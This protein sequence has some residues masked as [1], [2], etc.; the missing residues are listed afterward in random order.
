M[1]RAIQDAYQADIE[2][3]KSGCVSD[4]DKVTAREGSDDYAGLQSALRSQVGSRNTFRLRWA[5]RGQGS[6]FEK[7]RTPSWI[8]SE[9]PIRID[10]SE[11][12]T[13]YSTVSR[14]YCSMEAPGQ[15]TL[16][17]IIVHELTGHGIGTVRSRFGFP[18]GEDAA[19]SWQNRIP[20]PGSPAC[21]YRD[22]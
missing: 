15:W 17:S 10:A 4:P 16:Q 14:G 19:V 12:G 5:Q 18:G 3:D 8:T 7:P 6:K 1:R 9:Y 20:G 11:I 21:A 2:W 22:F 13:N